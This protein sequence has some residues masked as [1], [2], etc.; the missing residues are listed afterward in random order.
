MD[1]LAANHKHTVVALHWRAVH[2]VHDDE[3]TRPYNPW[4]PERHLQ[5]SSPARPMQSPQPAYLSIYLTTCHLKRP[6]A[7][8]SFLKFS[9]HH[10]I[11][12]MAAK[13]VQM[14]CCACQ[15]GFKSPIVR[16]KLDQVNPVHFSD[17][18]IGRGTSHRTPQMVQGAPPHRPSI[19][20]SRTWAPLVTME[21][22]APVWAR[23]L[24]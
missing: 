16:V 24:Q 18:G 17:G 22:P 14:S 5:S 10:R 7:I 2:T 11:P 4:P 12:S 21:T 23:P 19:H 1:M 9:K 20:A 15:I 3:M 6:I 8:Y 13:Q